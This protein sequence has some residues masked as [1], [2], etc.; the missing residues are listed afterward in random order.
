MTSPLRRRWMLPLLLRESDRLPPLL[1]SESMGP[2][3]GLRFR[4]AKM[5]PGL[6]GGRALKAARDSFPVARLSGLRA[7]RTFEGKLFEVG[8][9]GRTFTE[10]CGLRLPSL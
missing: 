7:T 10:E 9:A 5:R 6:G 4:L 3:N 2:L 1:P 8:V